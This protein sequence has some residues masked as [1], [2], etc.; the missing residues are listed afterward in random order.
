MLMSNKKAKILVIGCVSNDVV[1]LE[2]KAVTVQNLGGAGLYSSL[3]ILASGIDCTLLAPR[4][5]NIAALGIKSLDK[6]QW[7]GPQAKENEFPHLEIIH[8]G[9]DRAT[10]CK[11]GWGI[12]PDM[13]PA[14]LPE[15]LSQFEII[16]IAALSSAARQMSFVQEIQ[17]R[18]ACKI[19]LGTYAR[20]A[21]AATLTV[22][23]CIELAH[24]VFMNENEA[25][26]IFD[27]KTYAMRTINDKVFC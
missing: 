16:H 20:V 8:H 26:I 25:N 12:E 10:L 3:A 6:L 13:V 15:D 14:Q 23:R 9:N 7:L 21:A 1:H 27:E 19:S 18:S 22:R 24:F 17:R 2:P 4:P 5:A 11:A